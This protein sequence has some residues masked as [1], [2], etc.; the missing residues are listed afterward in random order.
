MVPMDDSRET[1]RR[2]RR[3][4]AERRRRFR[5]PNQ[6]HFPRQPSSSSS[7][8]SSSWKMTKDTMRRTPPPLSDAIRPERV[9]ESFPPPASP[10]RGFPGPP[11]A[12]ARVPH[13][14]KKI[15]PFVPRSPSRSRRRNDADEPA[16]RSDVT[17]SKRV[18]SS[19]VRPVQTLPLPRSAF[20]ERDMCIPR[21]IPRGIERTHRRLA[22]AAHARGHDAAS[23][24]QRVRG[25][26]HDCF[27]VS[28][29]GAGEWRDYRASSRVESSDPILFKH[30][31]ITPTHLSM[32]KGL[33]N[34]K[35][36]PRKSYT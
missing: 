5:R 11:I 1:S 12:R 7:S 8:S 35:I 36:W 21:G 10:A 26:H 22:R 29:R 28:L 23:R 15:H 30:G 9:A 6:G 4:A 32:T 19:V 27:R 20:R 25:G 2:R 13:G 31:I 16:R 33:F 17:R 34:R 14:H 3:R 24:S 18:T